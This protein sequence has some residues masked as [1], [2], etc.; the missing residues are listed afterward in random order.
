[1]AMFFSVAPDL[2]II[3]G[4]IAG[5]IGAYHNQA[6]HSLFFGAVVCMV[7]AL[8]MRRFLKGWRIKNA[9]LLFWACYGVHLALDLMTLGPGLQLFWPFSGERFSIPITLFYG[10]RHSEGLFSFHHVA[11]LVNEL[12]LVVG[13]CLFARL[14]FPLQCQAVWS[15]KSDNK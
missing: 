5:H 13:L 9:L 14:V 6:S 2:D 11:T 3:P 4:L 12:T 7:S 1:M 15:K 10:V 8:L